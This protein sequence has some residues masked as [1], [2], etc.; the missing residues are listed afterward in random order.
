MPPPGAPWNY[1]FLGVAFAAGVFAQ[2]CVLIADSQG[3]VWPYAGAFVA[4]DV[5]VLIRISFARL[6]SEANRG[7]LAY[8]VLCVAFLPLLYVAV[9]VASH[10]YRLLNLR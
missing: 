5:L 6:R 2:F 1:R 9:I 7:W 8:S 4:F 10:A 3:P